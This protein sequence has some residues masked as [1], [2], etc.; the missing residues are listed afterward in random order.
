[1]LYPQKGQKSQI[2]F[3]SQTK[4]SQ[5]N[6]L[7]KNPDFENLALKSQY[8]NPDTGRVFWS[9]AAWLGHT[10]RVIWHAAVQRVP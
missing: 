1:M 10:G 6:D 5:A 3:K 7:Q 4:N 9:N 2:L 8:G